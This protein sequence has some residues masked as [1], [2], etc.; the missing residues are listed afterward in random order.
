MYQ[1]WSG[2]EDLN[3]RHPAPKAGTL[4][5]CVTPR[6]TL[7]FID[8]CL[9]STLAEFNLLP[10]PTPICHAWA[11]LTRPGLP[12]QAPPRLF[13]TGLRPL[14]LLIGFVPKVC[15][16]IGGRR[17]A[18][19]FTGPTPYHVLN[20]SQ[21]DPAARVAL[22]KHSLAFLR[23]CGAVGSNAGAAAHHFRTGDGENF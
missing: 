18:N 23:Y 6:F 14:Y 9:F 7:V 15:K 20:A 3:L 11:Y 8:V 16:G 19:V 4:P 13:V 17:Q 10:Q 22:C 1:G 2:R 5:D 12:A 21:R